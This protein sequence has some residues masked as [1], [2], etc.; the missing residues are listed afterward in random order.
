MSEDLSL[1]AVQGSE[2]FSFN[3]ENKLTAKKIIGK[4]PKGR[5]ASGP[6]ARR[7]GLRAL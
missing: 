7:S 5:G 1:D 6:S 4:Y 3:D 2:I